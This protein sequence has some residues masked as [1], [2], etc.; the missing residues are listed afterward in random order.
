MSSPLDS[1]P[2][3]P[4]T[5]YQREF[6]KL[7]KVKLAVDQVGVEGQWLQGEA[8]QVSLVQDRLQ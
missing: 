7:S 8:T 6:K 3:I 5:L 2:P 4:F 1:V